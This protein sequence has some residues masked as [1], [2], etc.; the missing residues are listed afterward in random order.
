M[1]FGYIYL[2]ISLVFTAVV[3]ELLQSVY[4]CQSYCKN[5][6]DQFF[7]SRCISS[8]KDLPVRA[9]LRNGAIRPTSQGRINFKYWKLL[10]CIIT[11]EPVR[12]I[13]ITA[14]TTILL[15]YY[16]PFCGHHYRL[17]RSLV[18]LSERN[19]WDCSPEVFLHARRPSCHQHQS[20]TT[21][22]AY[23]DTPARR[24]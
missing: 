20:Q 9:V 24:I 16:F 17:G 7:D 15:V 4:N 23:C 2:H 12:I 3:K 18:D 13:T 5:T 6:L 11:R 14:T 21:S 8:Y 22:S 19:V 10:M 1:T